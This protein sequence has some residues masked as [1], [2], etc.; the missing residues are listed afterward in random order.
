[1][2]KS[3]I[4]L[5]L[6]ATGFILLSQSAKAFTPYQGGVETVIPF[7][8]GVDSGKPISFSL[9]LGLLTSFVIYVFSSSR[10]PKKEKRNFLG[11][12]FTDFWF[13]GFVI[14]GLGTILLFILYSIFWGWIYLLIWAAASG[15]LSI[16]NYFLSFLAG[17]VIYAA[18]RAMIESVV[19]IA[20]IAESTNLILNN[21]ANNKS[22]SDLSPQFTCPV[23]DEKTGTVT[24]KKRDPEN[25]TT[26]MEDQSLRELKAR[27]GIE[28]DLF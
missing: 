13:D 27:G 18:T 10:R 5:A 12:L 26:S 15:Y 6:L 1:M 20:K 14:P 11:V 23:L 24:M 4:Y 3:Y 22:E 19:S 21:L 25:W 7:A 28:T 8:L 2:K 9:L 16:T 17:L